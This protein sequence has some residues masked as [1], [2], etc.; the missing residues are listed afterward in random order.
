M[1]KTKNYVF[2]IVLLFGISSCI[3]EDKCNMNLEI[4][5]GNSN[6][7]GKFVKPFNLSIVGNYYRVNSGRGYQN[8]KVSDDNPIT[9]FWG[10][11]NHPNFA[12]VQSNSKV[13]VT[14]T[15]NDECLD[16]NDYDDSNMSQIYT[17]LGVNDCTS[18]PRRPQSWNEPGMSIRDNN[19]VYDYIEF[20]HSNRGDTKHKYNMYIVSGP[21]ESDNGLIYN[22]TWTWERGYYNW[23]SSMELIIEGDRVGAIIDPLNISGA[24]INITPHIPFIKPIYI[25]GAMINQTL[26]NVQSASKLDLK[27]TG[28]Q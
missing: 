7:F 15:I 5:W 9:N 8:L 20:W 3:P 18:I 13:I 2:L 23:N 16:Y 24:A 28:I 1:K 19:E 11:F 21:Y 27:V 10:V 4:T 17:K 25:N 26:Q 6:N 12:G 22:L 14:T